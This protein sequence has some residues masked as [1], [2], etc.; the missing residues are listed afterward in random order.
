MSTMNNLRMTYS[1][2]Y[3][4]TYC[5][6]E[7]LIPDGA[8]GEGEDRYPPWRHHVPFLQRCKGCTLTTIV[9]IPG[10]FVAPD[11]A[12]CAFASVS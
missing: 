11:T 7:Q 6:N 10:K 5:V 9:A 4:A 2:V 12:H 1:R 3:G 8:Q